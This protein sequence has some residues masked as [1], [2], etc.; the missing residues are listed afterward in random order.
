MKKLGTLLLFSIFLIGCSNP[1]EALIPVDLESEKMEK[2]GEK[3]KSL[4]EE[5]KA[6]LNSYI[7]RSRE[8]EESEG[9]L[10]PVG[11]TVGDAIADENQWQAEVEIKQ[12]ARDEK[13]E[14]WAS[15]IDEKTA[16]F[17]NAVQ[18]TL[19]DLRYASGQMLADIRIDNNSSKTIIGI[20]S[21]L[22]FHD[23]FGESLSN[24]YY[25]IDDIE[26]PPEYSVERKVSTF[27]SYS[28]WNS[29]TDATY[30][31]LHQVLLFNDGTEIKIPGIS[32]FRSSLYSDD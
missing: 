30:E 7:A 23:K 32:E 25:V 27:L 10:I 28:S 8:S 20:K 9:F 2:L 22:I 16:E 12:K 13:Y 31:S 11:K 6:L 14:L 21:G 15:E 5:D 18:I 26:L 24:L 29:Y 19:L 3:V 1:K 4:S 17:N